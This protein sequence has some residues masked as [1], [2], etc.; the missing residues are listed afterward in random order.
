MRVGRR[1]HEE[2]DAW[3][4]P[5][6]PVS[7]LLEPR[8][9]MSVDPGARTRALTPGEAYEHIKESIAQYLETQYRI[10]HT[11]VVEERGAILRSPGTIAQ[12]P[13]IESTPAFPT[14]S[15]L[16]DLERNYPAEFVPGLAE[17]V[18][19]G[20]PVDRFP[21]YRH[22]ETAL[23]ASVGSHPNLLVAT[24]TG[25]GKTEAF[26][27]PILADVLREAASWES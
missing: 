1:P 9:R 24:G 14:A 26:L 25:S 17:L 21:L 10:S 18:Q 19:H 15:K 5:N 7:N 6:R 13:F 27:L 22:Q 11:A 4:S 2:Q 20:V 8:R 23:L 3:Q 16:A 12:V